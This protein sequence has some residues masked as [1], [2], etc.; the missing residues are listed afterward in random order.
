[1]LEE[2]FLGREIVGGEDGGVER[3]V[4]ILEGILAGEFERAIN[5]PQAAVSAVVDPS[6][7]TV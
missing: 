5:G 4:G 3:G 7:P 6:Q 1:L 2:V